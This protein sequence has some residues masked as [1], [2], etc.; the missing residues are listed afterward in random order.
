MRNERAVS[1]V[2]RIDI[3]TMA[4]YF[5]ILG[6]EPGPAVARLGWSGT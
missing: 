5:G 2:V 3:Y 1:F 4:E 6:K